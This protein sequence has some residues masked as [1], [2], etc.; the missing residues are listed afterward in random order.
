[1]PF[2]FETK[3]LDLKT[4]TFAASNYWLAVVDRSKNGN[5]HVIVVYSAGGGKAEDILKA[6]RRR[7]VCTNLGF[8]S[9]TGA[10]IG[11]LITNGNLINQDKSIYLQK[12][13]FGVTKDYKYV[14]GEVP[15]QSTKKDGKDVKLYFLPDGLVKKQQIQFGHSAIGMLI[16]SGKFH[17][18]GKG[19]PLPN[20]SARPDLRFI[21]NRFYNY[22]V[23]RT[24][25]G[26]NKTEDKFFVV[27]GSA[28]KVSDTRDFFSKHIPTLFPGVTI[29]YA[30][31]G[32]GSDK[33]TMWAKSKIGAIPQQISS[34]GGN[35]KSPTFLVIVHHPTAK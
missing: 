7:L 12:D 3:G 32:D 19:F 14:G 8:Y 35:P 31:I 1:M 6:D 17:S 33:S 26:W 29:D 10:V 18:L 2:Q 22:T 24:A 5:L 13:Y 28:W 9:K 15:P 34:Q 4:G 27:V 16:K 20:S 25:W 11:D 21:R 23:P 30:F